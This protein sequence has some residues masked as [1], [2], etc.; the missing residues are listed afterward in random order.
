[1]TDKNQLP[2]GKMKIKRY[3]RKICVNK[4]N[5]V[6]L[7]NLLLCLLKI[8]FHINGSIK[9]LYNSITYPQ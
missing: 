3:I 1:M 9:L 4:H 5:V 6:Q 7:I 2:E 8:K